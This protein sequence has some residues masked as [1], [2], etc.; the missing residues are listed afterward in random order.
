M[1]PSAGSR[2]ATWSGNPGRKAARNLT[3][4]TIRYKRIESQP[5]SASSAGS[6]RTGRFVVIGQLAM[7]LPLL[8]GA[9]MLLLTLYNLQR[10]DLGFQRDHLVMASLGTLSLLLCFAIALFIAFAVFTKTQTKFGE[11]G[12]ID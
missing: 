1:G 2:T 4:G 3:D 9:G 6:R 12:G 11:H 5:V 8:V 10:A 7:S